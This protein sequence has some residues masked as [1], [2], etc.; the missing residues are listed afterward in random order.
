MSTWFI[1]MIFAASALA[2]APPDTRAASQ[3]IAIIYASDLFHPH[4]DPDDHFDLATLFA[5]PDVDV[6]AIVLD[7]GDNQGI[8]QDGNENRAEMRR[9][10]WKRR[11]VVEHHFALGFLQGLLEDP[12]LFPVR[13]D[14][15]FDLRKFN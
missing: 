9:P 3:R 1:G 2:G 5:I 14:F 10:G 7:I 8:L 11:A 6:R 12:A 15:Q 13:Q 4:D